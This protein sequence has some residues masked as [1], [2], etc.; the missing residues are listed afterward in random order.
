MQIHVHSGASLP[1]MGRKCLGPVWTTISFCCVQVCL[2]WHLTIHLLDL[3][4]H[5]GCENGWTEC[6]EQW[7]FHC[8]S[9]KILTWSDELQEDHRKNMKK[10]LMPWFD[11]LWDRSFLQLS[12]FPSTSFKTQWTWGFNALYLEPDM[13]PR[14]IGQT[15]LGNSVYLGADYARLQ[16]LKLV[17]HPSTGH[18]ETLNPKNGTQGSTVL[19]SL[20][21]LFQWK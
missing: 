21:S 12:V 1:L 20:E 15:S 17:K 16:S 19:P 10:R 7:Q 9:S 4:K 3:G 14:I 8:P 13:N 6:S 2:W 5:L 18:H 11:V